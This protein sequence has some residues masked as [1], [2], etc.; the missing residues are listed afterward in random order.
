VGDEYPPGSLAAERYS[1]A[2][3]VQHRSGFI[4]FRMRLG[5]KSGGRSSG[6]ALPY[7]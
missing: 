2:D 7:L 5:T 3:P 6:L 4:L 1:M